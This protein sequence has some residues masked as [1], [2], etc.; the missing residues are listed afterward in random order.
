LSGPAICTCVAANRLPAARVL[1]QSLRRF[2][3]GIPFHVLLAAGQAD[4]RAASDDDWNLVRMEDL[5]IRDLPRMLRRY[6]RFQ[7]VVA[8][9]PAVLRHLL[10]AGYSPVIF[11][12]ADV[13]VLAELTPLLERVARHSLS[14]TP[15]VG[16]GRQT[17]ARA[18]FERRLL[19]T[20]MYNLGFVGASD[21]EETRRFLEWWEMRLRTHCVKALDRGLNYDQR[22][23]DLAPSLIADFNVVRDA[24]CNVAYWRLCEAVVT[25]V[26]GAYHIDGEPILFFHFS[27]F[28]PARAGMV[29]RHV[30]GWSIDQLGPERELFERYADLLEKA[31]WSAASERGWPWGPGFWRRLLRRRGV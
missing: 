25:R 10:E 28:S 27:G 12:D 2:C 23:A 21:R 1:A 18:R 31:G 24:G 5:G 7:T 17:E 20:G 6:D 26:D 9:K 4:L 8:L 29:S 30:P 14:L 16:P 15:H 13:L 19:M 22:W 3:P 11:L